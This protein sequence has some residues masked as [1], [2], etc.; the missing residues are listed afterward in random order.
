MRGRT[1]AAMQF[2]YDLLEKISREMVLY[3]TRKTSNVLE[4]SFPSVYRGRSLEFDDLKEY[5]PGDDV[6]AIDWKSSSRTDKLLIRRYIAE[7]KH[8]LLFALD[9]GLKM[10][11]D[12][13][14][15]E[16][17]GELALLILGSLCYILGKQGADFGY[18][19]GCP[20]G[21]RRSF[22]RCG[23]DHLQNLLAEYGETMYRE[24]KVSL[25]DL[26]EGAAER[27]KRRMILAVITDSEGLLQLDEELVKRLT[28][29]NDLIV[30]CLEDAYFT[31]DQVYDTG[32]R[33]YVD[34]IMARSA[35]LRD[36]ELDRREE[37]LETFLKIARRNRVG[38]ARISKADTV[39]DRILDLFEKGRHGIY[40]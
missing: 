31:G 27:E 30:F 19:Y 37:I 10:D 11:A 23:T 8:N 21:E 14:E 25:H 15:G 16:S 3:T 40:G 28:E 2:D 26:L 6:Q 7:K 39:V 13:D 9:T 20:E 18:V 33:S 12:T 32:V 22:F 38:F 24:P 5:S 34:R 4:G 36:L 17:K 35:K 29:R 1:L